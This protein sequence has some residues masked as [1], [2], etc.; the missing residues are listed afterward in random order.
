MPF[1]PPEED[2]ATAIGNM[3]E[4]FGKNGRVVPKTWSR[5][6]KYTDRQTRSSQ[7]TASLSGRSKNAQFTGKRKRKNSYC[8]NC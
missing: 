3:H 2:R 6:D 1:T 4:K 8:I 5:T 7:Y